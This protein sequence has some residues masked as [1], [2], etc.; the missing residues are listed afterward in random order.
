MPIDVDKFNRDQFLRNFPPENR[1]ERVEGV[2]IQSRQSPE[3]D[4]ISVNG[5]DHKGEVVEF[6][7]D[8]PN[9]MYLMSLLANIQS[10]SRA[11]VPSAAPDSCKPHDL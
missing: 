5:R 2:L 8:L 9:A 1:W 10:R 6:W 3:G 4:L 7:T 11:D